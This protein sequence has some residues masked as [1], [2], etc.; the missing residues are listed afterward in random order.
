MMAEMETLFETK[1]INKILKKIPELI[2]FQITYEK[3]KYLGSLKDSEKHETF[4]YENYEPIMNIVATSCR[5]FT[6]FKQANNDSLFRLK[7]RW[8]ASRASLNNQGPAEE[9]K[10]EGEPINNDPRH[11]H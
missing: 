1:D 6:D 3:L 4:F 8:L 10:G 5:P 2:E 11:G 9:V 7:W